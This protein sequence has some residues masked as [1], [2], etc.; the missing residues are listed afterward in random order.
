MN[1]LIFD[2]ST[3]INLVLNGLEE[4]L[5]KMKKLGD[6]RLIMTSD[7]KYETIKRPVQSKQ[8]ELGALKIK[9]LL[10]ANIIETPAS[11]GVKDDEIEKQTSII[12]DKTNKV[13]WARNVPVHLID[14]GEAS[15]LALYNILKNDR[16]I[17]KMALA[18]DERTTRMLGEKPENLRRLMEEK[19][20]AKVDM[21]EIPQE[22]KNIIFIRSAEIVYIAY[23]KGFIEI[24]DSQALDALLW[25]CKFSGCSISREEIEQ[26][27]KL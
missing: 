16:R 6:I 4:I 11:I 13:L 8:Y 27:K 22:I 25:A 21:K 20:H 9:G 26:I 23:K 15:C 5:P 10:D 24:K 14:K 2:S 19:L 12:L 17:N 1:V 18:V 7:V 3:I